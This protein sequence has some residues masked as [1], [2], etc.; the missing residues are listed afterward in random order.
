MEDGEFEF[1]SAVAL[2]DPLCSAADGHRTTVPWTPLYSRA[3]RHVL[4]SL[5][6]NCY[7]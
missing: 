2:F 6:H 1:W 4:S 7:T 5:L 3:V